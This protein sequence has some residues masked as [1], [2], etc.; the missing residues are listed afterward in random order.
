MAAVLARTS[1]PPSTLLGRLAERSRRT[2][3]AHVAPQGRPSLSVQDPLAR[4]DPDAVT[5]T[6]RSGL[7]ALVRFGLVVKGGLQ[8]LVGTLALAAVVGD[9]HGRI[10]DASGAL[11]TLA[12]E[13]YGRALLLVLA[14]GLFG[15]AGFRLFQ[16]LFDPERRPRTPGTALFR[17]A[18]LFS[19]VGYVL[20]GIGAVRLFLGLG[21]TT[22]DA[23]TRR[24][25]AEALALP[26]GPKMLLIFAGVIFVLALLFVA[27]AFIVRDVCGDLLTE[28][29]GVAGCRTAAALIRFASV[30]QAILFGTMATLFYRAAVAQNPGAVRGMGGVL[31]VISARQGTWVLGL[32]AVGFIAMAINSFIEARWR[33]GLGPA[34]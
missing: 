34:R 20:L 31:R 9:S 3:V 18:D 2:Y 13:R 26:Y 12:R 29:M 22:S 7:V 21:A 15:Y 10:T 4:I 17:V 1:Q 19:G 8:L 23:R 32:V 27:R 33:K 6:A 25:T 14:V 30:V 11:L 24:L 5:T 16:G 28:Q